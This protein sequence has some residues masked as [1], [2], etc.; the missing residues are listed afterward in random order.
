MHCLV[1]MTTLLHQLHVN[2]LQ[3]LV[4][5]VIRKAATLLQLPHS[6]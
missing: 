1:S 2:V 6:L 4:F 5:C 3:Q